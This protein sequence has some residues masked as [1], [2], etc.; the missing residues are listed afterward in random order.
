MKKI[1]LLSVIILL[2]TLIK[3]QAIEEIGDFRCIYGKDATKTI[4][5]ISYKGLK[6]QVNGTDGDYWGCV[7]PGYQY[8]VEKTKKE[9]LNIGV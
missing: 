8:T 6:G 2:P 7:S 9:L 3:A 1:V 4:Y 5:S